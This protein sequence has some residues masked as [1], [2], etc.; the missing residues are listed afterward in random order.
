MEME[1]VVRYRGALAYYRVERDSAG[2]YQAH[3][4]HFQGPAEAAPPHRVTLAKGIRHWVGSSAHKELM[5]DIGQ[6]IENCLTQ[7]RD[8]FPGQFAP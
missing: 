3:L 1:A 7:N 2:I 6:N 8:F 5:E 4:T